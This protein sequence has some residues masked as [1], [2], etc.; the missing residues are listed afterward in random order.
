MGACNSQPLRFWLFTDAILMV[1]AYRGWFCYGYSPICSIE[2]IAIYNS[3][4]AQSIES[5]LVASN[6]R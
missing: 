4:D 3:I 2:S 6:R 1:L 5:L